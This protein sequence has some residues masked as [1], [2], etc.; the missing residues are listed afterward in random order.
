MAVELLAYANRQKVADA[1]TEHGYAVTRM[2]VNRWARG[3][4]MPGIAAR[5]ILELF[6]HRSDTTKEPPPDW[7]RAM[8]A[9]IVGELKQNRE[10][11]EALARPELIEAAERVISRL[12]ALEPPDDEAP[13]GAVE[14][15]GRAAAAPPSQARG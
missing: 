12:E 6:G 3:G 7:A 2:T 13:R 15:E 8:E 14:S 1:L 5:M 11:I 4:E 10:L 9:R